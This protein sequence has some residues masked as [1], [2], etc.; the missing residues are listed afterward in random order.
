MVTQL[1]E[2]KAVLLDEAARLAQ[3]PGGQDG[4]GAGPGDTGAPTGDGDAVPSAEDVSE[5]GRSK[6]GGA[7]PGDAVSQSDTVSQSNTVSESNTTAA[8]LLTRFYRHVPYDDLADR[9]PADLLGA[10]RSSVELAGNRP[11]GSAKI[12]AFTPS[13]QRTGWTTGA[14][15][16]TVVE[17][18]TDDMPFLVDSVTAELKVSA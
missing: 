8:A 2:A 5:R 15:Q 7:V 4:E 6:P 10:V 13:A 3:A 12:R 17:I 11:Q 16:H 14:Q 9:A 1:D 18:V